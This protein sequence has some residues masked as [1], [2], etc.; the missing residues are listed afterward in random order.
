M[1]QIRKW[2]QML[3]ICVSIQIDIRFDS[4]QYTLG[5]RSDDLYSIKVY[6]RIDDKFH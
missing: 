2:F 3:S 5:F 6:N 4:D 1:L